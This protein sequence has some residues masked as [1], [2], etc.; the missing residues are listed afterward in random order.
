MFQM[1]NKMNKG[2]VNTTSLFK[3]WVCP[4][5]LKLT[6][7]KV[8]LKRFDTNNETNTSMSMQVP[9]GYANGTYSIT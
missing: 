4:K 2:E 3:H 1:S 8:V 9:Y 5:R 7:V 6:I